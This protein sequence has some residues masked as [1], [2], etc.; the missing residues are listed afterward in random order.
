MAGSA[1]KTT[2]SMASSPDSATHSEEPPVSRVSLTETHEWRPEATHYAALADVPPIKKLNPIRRD[3]RCPRRE[4]SFGVDEW[5]LHKSVWRHWRHIFSEA[6]SSTLQRLSFPALAVIGFSASSVTAYNTV[7]ADAAAGVAEL[8]LPALPF[9]IS[10]LVLGLLTTFRTNAA[11]DRFDSARGAWGEVIN[12]SRDLL[13][14]TRLWIPEEEDQ[15]RMATLVKAFPI[16]LNF[17]L[18]T[19]GGHHM[20][21]C[22]DPDIDEISL[23]ELYA[24]LLDRVWPEGPDANED[25]RAILD[26]QAGKGNISLLVLRLMGETLDA[27]MPDKRS[28]ASVELDR[29]IQ[30]LNT[31]LG[32]CERIL[33]TPIPVSYSRHTSRILTIWLN[34]L[35]FALYPVLGP[36]GTVPGSLLLSWGLLG[37]E[38]IGNQIEEPFNML[39]LRNY[40]EAVNAGFDLYFPHLSPAKI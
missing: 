17:F 12:A 8:A 1:K 23:Q 14:E 31:A 37:I 21:K 40:S 9:T 5:A 38:D 18:T 22:R 16:T 6:S 15:R 33:R 27:A 39:P 19:D 28:I 13:R 4:V 10:S 24:E 20:L 25:F 2:R 3:R 29:T 34:L 32:R 26:L 36:L 35:P 7:V 30:R 11:H